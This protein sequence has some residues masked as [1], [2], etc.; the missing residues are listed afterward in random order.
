MCA[1][2]EAEVIPEAKS[3]VDGDAR[4]DL[5]RLWASAAASLGCDRG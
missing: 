1:E 5:G 2:V 3:R 4:E